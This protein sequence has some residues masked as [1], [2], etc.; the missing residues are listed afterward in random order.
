MRGPRSR[1]L[2]PLARTFALPLQELR[3]HVQR[4]DQDA[5]GASA[6]EGTLA[7]SRQ[8]DDRRQ[9]PGEDRGA[10]WRSSDDGLCLRHRFLRAPAS[11]KPRSLRGIV[12]ADRSLRPCS[13]RAAGPTCRARPASAAERPDMRAFIRTTYPFL[14]PA[15]GRARPSTRSCLRS[16]ALR[17]KQRSPGSSRR[18]I[19]S[20]ATAARRSPLSLA[21]PGFRSTPYPRREADPQGAL[22][23]HQHR[24]RLPRPPQ[25]VAQPLQRRRHQ[26]PAQ[27]SRLATRP[28]RL[29]RPTRAANLDQRRHRKRPIPTANAIRAPDA[30]NELARSV[31]TTK[32]AA[33]GLHRLTLSRLA[34]AV[35]APVLAARG[36][37]PLSRIGADTIAARLAHRMERRGQ[38][39]PLS[40]SR[41]YA[42]IP[43]AIAGV[44]TEF[45]LAEVDARPNDTVEVLSAPGEGRECFEITRR[46]LS[47]ARGGIPFDRIAVLLRSPVG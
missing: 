8:S 34:F 22:P 14:S 43:R 20:S 11:D 27:L 24:Q 5:H 44:I 2:G 7:R 18:A 37:T 21:K 28:R 42:W 9:E 10:L 46:V 41:R 29:G 45:R 19:I 13:S 33:F 39:Q 4:A 23:A 17:W 6:Q 38:A 25:A 26:E 15:T 30:A 12:E 1:R 47:L 32:G 40:I 31:A 35:A 16:M 36:L 3:A